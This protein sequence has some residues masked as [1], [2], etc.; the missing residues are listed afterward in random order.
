MTEQQFP[1]LQASSHIHG[2][3]K[4]KG[5]IEYTDPSNT[6]RDRMS[7]FRTNPDGQHACQ[8]SVLAQMAEHYPRDE[9]LKM[10]LEGWSHNYTRQF[11]AEARGTS[12]N[13]SGQER[14]QGRQTKTGVDAFMASHKEDSPTAL[15]FGR[16]ALERWLI[17]VVAF[18]ARHAKTGLGFSE[19]AEGGYSTNEIGIHYWGI[20]RLHQAIEKL[21]AEHLEEVHFWMAEAQRWCFESW[22][23]YDIQGDRHWGYPYFEDKDHEPMHGPVSAE[24]F[25]WLA[26]V[27]YEPQNP[28]EEAKHKAI[29]ELG[30]GMDPR[31]TR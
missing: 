11:P 14:D 22:R 13:N 18:K 26:A 16:R 31:F 12:H 5:W 24:H 23:F 4:D 19:F 10:L 9:G 27:H 25:G 17:D 30:A 2:R 6:W 1:N 7:V 21:G 8:V 20:R 3:S 29:L 15:R 28:T